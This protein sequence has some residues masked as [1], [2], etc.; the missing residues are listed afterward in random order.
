MHIFRKRKCLHDY[1]SD[2]LQWSGERPR[3]MPILG[4][5]A[6]LAEVAEMTYYLVTLKAKFSH[7]T[8]TSFMSPGELKKIKKCPVFE[9][10]QEVLLGYK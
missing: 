7:T 5:S 10:V 2:R 9:V 4:D 1:V 8:I 6:S 3:H